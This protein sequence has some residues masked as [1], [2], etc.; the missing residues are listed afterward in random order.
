[1]RYK[2]VIEYDGSPFKGWQRQPKER[3]VQGELERAFSIIFQS[4]I[5]V[6][7]SGRT[8]TGVHARNQIA[9]VDFPRKFD[10]VNVIKSVNNLLLGEVV[11][12]KIIKV[13]EDFD[14]RFD[15]TERM[16]RYYIQD[17]PFAINRHFIVSHNSALNVDLLNDYAKVLIGKHDFTAFSKTRSNVDHYLSIVYD[18]SWKRKNGVVVFEISAIRFLRGMVRAIVGMSLVLEKQMKAPEEFLRILKSQDRA[19]ARYHAPAHGLVL[20]RVGYKKMQS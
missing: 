12:K 9:H 18:A 8:D 1:M 15:A 20:E 2:L 7:G 14:S 16:Y 6:Q 5:H 10:K 4:P 17:K 11:V 13:K 3:T 19:L